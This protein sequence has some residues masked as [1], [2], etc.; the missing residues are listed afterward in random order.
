MFNIIKTKRNKTPTA[1]TYM[2]KKDTGKNSKL[3]RN[4]IQETLKKEKI[5]NKTEKIGFREKTTKTEDRMD[6]VVKM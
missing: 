1:P 4:K 3:N 5:K 2:T 6:N